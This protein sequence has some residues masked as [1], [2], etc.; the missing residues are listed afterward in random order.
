MFPKF[1]HMQGIR[2]QLWDQN[3]TG[4]TTLLRDVIKGK[5]AIRLGENVKMAYLFRCMGSALRMKPLFL[6][7]LDAGFDTDDPG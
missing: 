3:G 1:L 5:A 2:L 7:I 4:K 6:R